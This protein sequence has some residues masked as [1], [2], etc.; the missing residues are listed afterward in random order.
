M[1]ITSGVIGLLTGVGMMAG[2]TLLAAQ[3]QCQLEGTPVP[4]VETAAIPA[5]QFQALHSKMAPRGEQERWATIP[6]ATD[7]RAA[8]EKSAREGKPILMWMMDGHP[9]GCT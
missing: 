1:K 9:L 7:L 8:R 4:G 3:P 6:W 2:G 5:E